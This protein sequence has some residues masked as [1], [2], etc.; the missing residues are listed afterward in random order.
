MEKLKIVMCGCTEYGQL[1]L[2]RLIADGIGFDH[3]VLLTPEQGERY[4]I[5][6][7]KDL[8]P[9]ADAHGIPVLVPQD[10]SLTQKD[11]V[12]FFQEQRFDLLIQG[13][14][15][16]LFPVEILRT[17]R[18]GAVGIHG[19]TDL[20]PKGRGRSPLNW[21]LLEGRTRFLLQL[22]VMRNGAD[23]GPVFDYEAFDIN[24]H[25][26]IRT[27]YFKN[28]IATERM[29][30]RSLPKLANGTIELRPQKGVPTYYT[31]RAPEDGEIKWEEMDVDH[32]YNL[33]RATTRPYPGAFGTIDGQIC[34]IWRAQIFDTRLVYADAA[35]GEVVEQFDGL[36]VINCRG[37]L[38][39]VEDYEPVP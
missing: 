35:Y 22:F 16:R 29:L 33:I 30:L 17:L 15:Q 19:S 28:V 5:S 26:S 25:D 36:L 27:L 37:G 4:A 2:E 32:I 18:L 14:W 21:S 3:F 39:L 23:D 31:K 38:L 7:Y 12:S 9:L 8:R 24:A 34:T 11:D 13:G 6:G 10:Y 20:L 1:L